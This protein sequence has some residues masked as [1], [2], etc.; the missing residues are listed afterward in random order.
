MR[1]LTEDERALK[2][3]IENTE[4]TFIDFQRSFRTE[5]PKEAQ[6]VGDTRIHR[7]ETLWHKMRKEIDYHQTQFVKSEIE[8]CEDE[9][10]K[11][12]FMYTMGRM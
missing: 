9:A 2:D 10:F 11:E 12:T 1:P 4:K 7:I 6:F 5:V 8:A 3:L